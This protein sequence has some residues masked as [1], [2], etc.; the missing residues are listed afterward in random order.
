MVDILCSL[1]FLHLNYSLLQSFDFYL[2]LLVVLFELADHFLVLLFF[3][4][5]SCCV[6]LELTQLL[7]N[8]FQLPCEISIILF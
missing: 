8:I 6:L 3:Y 1:S 4:L 2:E 7:A 5:K